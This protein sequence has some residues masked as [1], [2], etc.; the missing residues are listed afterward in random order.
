MPRMYGTVADSPKPVVSVRYL[1]T[2]PPE[3]PRPFGYRVDL[4]LS[5][6]RADS[7]AE[8]ESTTV[9][10]RTWRSAPVVLSM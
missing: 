4:E 7:Q 2:I 6:R 5:S 10:Q 1:P 3:F 9:R 8:A